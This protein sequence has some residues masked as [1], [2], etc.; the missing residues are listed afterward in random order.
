VLTGPV[1]LDRGSRGFTRWFATE[2]VALPAKGAF[3]N[4][5]KDVFRGPG[6]NNWDISVFKNIPLKERVRMQIPNGVVQPFQPGQF[7]QPQCNHNRGRQLRKNPR[8][9]RSARVNGQSIF[10]IQ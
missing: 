7:Q 1:Q 4:A 2:N 6:T 5:P 10:H 8:G 9:E 3:G